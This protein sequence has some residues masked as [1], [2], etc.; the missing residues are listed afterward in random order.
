M[1]GTEPP[2]PSLYIPDDLPVAASHVLV[3]PWDL[4]PGFEG[5]ILFPPPWGSVNAA[6]GVEGEAR[7]A[8]TARP[9][10][11]D[12]HLHGWLHAKKNT[13]AFRWCLPD[14]ASSEKA[15]SAACLVWPGQDGGELC[16]TGQRA[17]L[18]TTF[19]LWG[20]HRFYRL[21]NFIFFL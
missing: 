9:A 16:A 4:D 20:F 10:M 7:A 3:G 18:H 6:A 8:A 17:S 21:H 13:R 1:N 5:T 14:A 15:V 11:P 2:Y 12:L 19:W